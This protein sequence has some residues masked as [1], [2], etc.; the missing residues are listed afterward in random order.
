MAFY[1]KTKKAVNGRW[2]PQA[3]TAGRPMTMDEVADRLAVMSSLSKGDVYNV[4]LNL[5]LV[6]R[7]A[8]AEGQSVRLQGMGTFWYTADC[9]PG[10]EESRE[11]CGVHQIKRVHVRFIPEYSRRQN[12]SVATRTLTDTPL[13][14]ID[15]EAGTEKDEDASI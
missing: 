12:C 11:S 13:E 5:P 4:L 3:V 10:G 6:M 15:I 9:L 8:M 7:Q 2:Y 1:R 14:W